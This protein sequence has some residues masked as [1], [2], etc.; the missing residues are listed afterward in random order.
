MTDQKEAVAFCGL[1]CDECPIHAGKIADLARDLRKELRSARFDRT[2]ETLSKLSFFDVFKD[3]EQCYGVLGG[4]VRFR[5]KHVCKSGG[6][7][8]FC[9]IRKCCQK[10]DIE[11]CWMCSEFETCELLN[12]LQGNHGVAHVKNL[13]KIQKSGIDGFLEG[14]KHWYVKPKGE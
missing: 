12:E 8:P 7:S 5:C 9:K 11:G 2:A 1:Y 4:M 3:Y 6:G 13:R 10:K 14:P